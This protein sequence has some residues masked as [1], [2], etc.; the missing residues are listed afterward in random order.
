MR[1]AGEST[2]PI[3]Q[4]CLGGV[5]IRR[6][7]FVNRKVHEGPRNST[8]LPN[9]FFQAAVRV[10]VIQDYVKRLRQCPSQK[11]A[12][13]VPRRNVSLLLAPSLSHLTCSSQYCA[14]LKVLEAMACSR[15]RNITHPCIAH[16]VV[17]L[18]QRPRF[19]C[20]GFG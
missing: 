3:I 19:Q 12:V 5:E 11:V 9:T 4:S 18:L 15:K 8:E 14:C 6:A 20:G 16:V 1:S 7:F 2:A 17:E 13:Q 10:E